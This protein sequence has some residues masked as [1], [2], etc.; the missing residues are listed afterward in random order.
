M[1]KVLCWKITHCKEVSLVPDGISVQEEVGI[2]KPVL[3]GAAWKIRHLF[4]VDDTTHG[5]I[6]LKSKD[7][8]LG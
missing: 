4:T 2:R 7:S 1:K 5:V 8:I 6:L 3:E